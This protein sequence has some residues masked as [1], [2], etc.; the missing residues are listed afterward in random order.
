MF[1]LNIFGR[2]P[3]RTE[4]LSDNKEDFKLKKESEEIVDGIH[5]RVIELLKKEG[6]SPGDLDFEKRAQEIT[7]RVLDEERKKRDN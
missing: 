5:A 3:E 7:E 2:Q 6:V 4:P 1:N